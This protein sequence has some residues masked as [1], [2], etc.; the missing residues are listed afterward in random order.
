M[1]KLKYAGEGWT[2]R[3]LN[4][5]VIE[6]LKKLATYLVKEEGFDDFVATRKGASKTDLTKYIDNLK[7]GENVLVGA[8][9]VENFA[10]NAYS[11]DSQGTLILF[12]NKVVFVSSLVYSLKSY[13]TYGREN[14]KRV[15]LDSILTDLR[16]K[17]M[18]AGNFSGTL[19]NFFIEHSIDGLNIEEV[20]KFLED[21]KKALGGMKLRICT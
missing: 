8:T 15:E 10:F 9:E 4:E 3:E 1:P 12:K 18:I 7:T 16:Q 13:T 20:K 6:Q 5:P 19:D 21:L 11:G 2:A 17:A 14:E